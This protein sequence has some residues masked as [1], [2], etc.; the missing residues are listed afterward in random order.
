[1][2]TAKCIALKT[3]L[4]SQAEPQSV[5]I[6]RFFDGNDDTGSI[7]CNLMDHP[8]IPEFQRT[9]MHVLAHPDVDG[10]WA[11]ISELD[12][13]EDCWPFAD[14]VIVSGKIAV[15][16]LCKLVE[17]LQPSEVGEATDFHISPALRAMQTR[18]LIIWWD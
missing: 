15:D 14:T 13:G 3:E 9:L 12:P 1:M 17:N 5:P 8:G 2:D 10:V 4:G 7:G 11:Q 6:E 16:A 18:L